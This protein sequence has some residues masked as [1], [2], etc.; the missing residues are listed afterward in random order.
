MNIYFL[1]FIIRILGVVVKNYIIV[2]DKKY[3][4]MFVYYVLC[5]SCY[6]FFIIWNFLN[7]LCK[8][9]IKIDVM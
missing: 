7:F 5:F 1:F 8:K 9:K 6:F 4:Y 3:S 2:V